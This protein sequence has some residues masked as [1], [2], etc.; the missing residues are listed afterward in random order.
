MNGAAMSRIV[1]ILCL[2]LGAPS[3]LASTFLLTGAL[4]DGAAVADGLFT[5]DFAILA[6]DDQVAWSERQENVIVTTGVFAV[7]VGAATPLPPG[8]PA[9]ARLRVTIDDD[10]LPAFP[11]TDLLVATHVTHADVAVRA[12]TADQMGD[13]TA[14]TAV[15]VAALAAADGPTAPFAAVTTSA[16]VKDGDD[17]V[18]VLSAGAGLTLGDRRLSVVS[19]TA[20]DRFAAGSIDGARFAAGTVASGKLATS[21]VTGVKVGTNLVRSTLQA[22]PGEAQIAGRDL[23]EASST[24]CVQV[25]LTTLSVCNTETCDTGQRNGF[26]VPILGRRA[27]VDDGSCSIVNP[28]TCANTRVGLLVA[29]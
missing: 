13:V 22:D 3:S 28:S 1:L 23:F 19:P 24:G 10:V 17:G 5:F 18:D 16:D 2:A 7:D 9:T 14:A 20:G 11:L 6:A 8:L 25:G 12:A 21:S 29:P 4:D 26:G 15:R 27:C